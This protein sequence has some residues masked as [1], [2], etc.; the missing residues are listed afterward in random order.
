MTPTQPGLA[1]YLVVNKPL[2]PGQQQSKKDATSS[3]LSREA[4]QETQGSD[5]RGGQPQAPGSYLLGKVV[6]VSKVPSPPEL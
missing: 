5:A 3:F 2:L 4:S 1:V 6:T